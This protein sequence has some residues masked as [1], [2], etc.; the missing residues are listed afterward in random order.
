MANK[1]VDKVAVATKH[2]GVFM[3]TSEL[4]AETGEVIPKSPKNEIVDKD[5]DEEEK[6][7]SS[8]PTTPEEVKTDEDDDDEMNVE[9][10]KRFVISCTLH[11]IG[12]RVPTIV[13]HFLYLLTNYLLLLVR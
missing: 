9:W 10:R 8:A 13:L 4:V 1:S 3:Q 2:P 12:S 6:T 5:V 11:N 7:E